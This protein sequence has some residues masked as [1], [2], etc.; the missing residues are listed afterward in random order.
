MY[1]DVVLAGLPNV[2]SQPP[3]YDVA[4]FVLTCPNAAGCMPL[5]QDS[6]DLLHQKVTSPGPLAT[7]EDIV[8]KHD[9]DHN[10]SG[11]PYK[12]EKKRTDGPRSGKEEQDATSY[13]VEVNG[14][15]SRVEFEDLFAGQ[16]ADHEFMVKDKQVWCYALEDCVV[17][18]KAPVVRRW[19]EY[20]CGTEKRRTS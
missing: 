5:R 4:R 17:S 8:H 9:K 16:Q 15:I 18:G 6:L 1:G 13:A 3:S 19:G 10:P 14:P 20:L 12:G 7:F 2:A 11:V